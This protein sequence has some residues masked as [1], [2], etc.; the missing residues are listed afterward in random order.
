MGIFW[1][2][3]IYSVWFDSALPFFQEPED[4]IIRHT[5]R[6]IY[7]EQESSPSH[8]LFSASIR[9]TIPSSDQEHRRYGHPF[10]SLRMPPR[11]PCI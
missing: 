4:P 10:P 9:H 5:D 7:K 2:F 3:M 1:I 8:T 11:N 6:D